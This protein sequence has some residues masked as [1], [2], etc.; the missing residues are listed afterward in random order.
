MDAPGSAVKSGGDDRT[1]LA[2]ER[3]KLAKERTF[4]AWI[5][6]GLSSAGI[7]VALVKLLPTVENRV[8]VQA[9]GVL[10]V[11]AGMGTLVL[12]IRSYRDVVKRLEA[13]VEPA[14]P[15]WTAYTLTVVFLAA[16]AIGLLAII[17]D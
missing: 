13:H 5:R 8:L 14:V 17:L 15:V 11:V 9:L 2:A 6:T 10:F 7:G 12:A 1:H 4:A 16:S 3:T